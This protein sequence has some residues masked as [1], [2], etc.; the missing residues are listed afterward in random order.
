MATPDPKEHGDKSK[1]KSD[2]KSLK[3]GKIKL[4]NPLA[5]TSTAGIWEGSQANDEDSNNATQSPSQPESPAASQL[6]EKL[7]PPVMPA[8]RPPTTDST[9]SVGCRHCKKR[10]L[11]TMILEH[12]T[13]CLRLKMERSK[14]KKEAKDAALREKELKEKAKAKA[15]D[16]EMADA[17]NGNDAEGEG[18]GDEGDEPKSKDK[19][20]GKVKASKKSSSKG[21]AKTAAATATDEGSKKSK[22]RKAEADAEKAPKPKKKKEEPKPKLVKPKGPVDVEKQCGVILP[23]GAMC[24]RSLTCKSH[25]MGAKRAVPGRSLPYDMLLQAYQKKNQAKQ[26][27]AAIDANAPLDDEADTQNG[28]VD[29]DEEKDAVMAGIARARAQ[30][31]ESRLFIPQRK[32]Y[33]FIRMKEMLATAMGGNRGASLFSTSAAFPEVEVG[34]V[35]SQSVVSMTTGSTGLEMSP[36]GYDGP[37]RR[38][39]LMQQALIGQNRM[40]FVSGSGSKRASVSTPSPA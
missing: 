32:K 23:N 4:K 16:V 34:S 9:D 2:K 21:S 40:P 8:Q 39:S 12:V 18:V 3:L 29:S 27:K 1:P 33:Q 24:A 13:E 10:F 11:R 25:S 37:S 7:A 30:P 36:T 15:G 38:Q 22:K 17:P 26:Q 28:V 5:K 31:L 19:D 35:R 20:G 6:E 14:K